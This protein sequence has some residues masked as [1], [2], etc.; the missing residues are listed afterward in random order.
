MPYNLKYPEKVDFSQSGQSK[1]VA[2]LL[3]EQKRGFFVECGAY[4]G[5]E[6]SN[7]LFLERNLNW[8]GL[9]IEADPRKQGVL[10]TKNRKAWL[11]RSCIGVS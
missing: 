10:R 7:T 9:L 8:T 6:I 2:N 11:A 1:I 3:K 5:E 4:D